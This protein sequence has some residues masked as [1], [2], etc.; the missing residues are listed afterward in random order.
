MKRVNQKLSK[1]KPLFKRDKSKDLQAITELS[2]EHR[3]QT[4]RKGLKSKRKYE[5]VELD[6][7]GIPYPEPKG[8]KTK[9]LSEQ[10][11]NAIFIE[12]N[13]KLKFE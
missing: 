8:P 1:S 13:K 4:E 9:I 3:Y 5:T 12:H 10:E 2:E 11:V 7:R 6:H